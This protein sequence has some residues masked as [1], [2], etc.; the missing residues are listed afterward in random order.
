MTEQHQAYYNMY[1]AVSQSLGVLPPTSE[2]LLLYE[3]TE[4]EMLE[5]GFS[6]DAH[7]KMII[8][9]CAGDSNRVR[10]QL[11]SNAVESLHPTTSISNCDVEIF[12]FNELSNMLVDVNSS[13]N[14]LLIWSHHGGSNQRFTFRSGLLRVSHSGMVLTCNSDGNVIQAPATG[15]ENQSWSDL[16]SFVTCITS[17][18]FLTSCE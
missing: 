2:M 17:F 3:A 11:L 7:L 9:K 16:L 12:I 4:M 18:L 13:G 14:N 5:E 15:A 1:A 10:M 8:V 6:D